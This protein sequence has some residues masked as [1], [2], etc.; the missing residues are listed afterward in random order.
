MQRLSDILNGTERTCSLKI[1]G[2]CY[3]WKGL[4]A[5]GCNINGF[6]F[7]GLVTFSEEQTNLIVCSRGRI[8]RCWKEALIGVGI[9][10]VRPMFFGAISC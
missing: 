8:E 10:G 7:L 2:F 1:S 6:G 9:V 5:C 4:F 3:V